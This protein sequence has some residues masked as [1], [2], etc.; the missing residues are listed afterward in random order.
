MNAASLRQVAFEGFLTI[1]A[2]MESLMIIPR[3]Q[4]V[5][6]VLYTGLAHPKFLEKGTGGFFKDKDPNVSIAEL[7]ANW[8]DGAD[9]VYIGKAGGPSSS[10]TLQS[11][12]TQYLKFGMGK[13]IGHW[14]GRYIWQISNSNDLVVC[15]KSNDENPREVEADMITRFKAE[16]QGRRPFANL[17]D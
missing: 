3:Q 2:L 13:K 16:H 14:G 11:R 1:A 12:L 5:Y 10:A 7:E 4:G 15:W 9:I 8:I 17:S 6:V